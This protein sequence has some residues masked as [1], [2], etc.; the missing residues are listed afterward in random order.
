MKNV[1]LIAE[2]VFLEKLSIKKT[3]VYIFFM[4]LS[5]LLA[6]KLGVGTVNSNSFVD[7]FAGLVSNYFIIGLFWIAGIPFIIYIGSITISAIAKE[8]NDGTAML[9]FTR[10]IMRREFLLG[11]LSGILAYTTTINLVIIYIFASMAAILY[12]S[13]ITITNGI[14]RAATSIFIYSFLLTIFIL[15]FSL[16]LSAYITKNIVNMTILF[17]LILMIFVMPIVLTNTPKMNNYQ[18]KLPDFAFIFGSTAI[19]SLNVMG[20][21]LIYYNKDLMASS[22]GVYKKYYTDIYIPQYVKEPIR[23]NEIKLLPLTI[24]ILIISLILLFLS[25]IK[26][27]S[28]EIQ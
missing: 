11:K 9:I 19:E 27:N 14:Y 7:K 28:L 5:S 13:D 22:I 4:I 16:F 21:D 8:I 23:I 3:F 12:G 10:P 15:S 25:Y 2:Q 20:L 17:V 18:E 24:I 26:L 6:F 1:L